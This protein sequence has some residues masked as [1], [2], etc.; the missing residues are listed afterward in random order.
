ME[1]RLPNLNS[2]RAFEAAARRLSFS[3]AA[4]ELCVTQGAV[5]RQIKSLE[6]DLGIKLF[7]RLTRAV[8]LTE[9]G[10]TYAA[11]IRDVFDRVERATL[12]LRSVTERGVLTV[13]VLP[14]FAMHYLIPRLPRFNAANPDVEVRM[15]MSIEAVNFARDDVDLAIRVGTPPK[16]TVRHSGPRIDLAMVDDWSQVRADLLAPDILVP[17]CSREFLETHG[18]FRR[19][20]DLIGKPLVHNATRAHAWPDWFEASGFD[21]DAAAVGPKFGHFFMAMQAASGGLGLALIPAILLEA[22]FMKAS[23]C[24]LDSLAMESAGSYYLVGRSDRWE[25]ERMKRF[26]DWLASE[27]KASTTLEP[28][29][30]DTAAA[31]GK[32][33]IVAQ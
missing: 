15:I 26:R 14:T 5:S 18:P 7:R 10:K 2:L 33:T 21:Y 31:T 1:R 4:D 23:L 17:V 16:S 29:P 19:P 30:L 12:Q 24:R 3:L 13:N 20:E 22:D 32:A 8:Q 27:C 9:E 28:K 11:V 25:N 6:S